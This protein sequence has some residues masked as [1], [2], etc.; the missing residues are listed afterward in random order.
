MEK[1]VFLFRTKPRLIAEMICMNEESYHDLLDIKIKKWNLE[2]IVYL[3]D[4]PFCNNSCS[5]IDSNLLHI[6]L[7]RALKIV[8][9]REE[10][11]KSD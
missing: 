11:Y 10:N 5:H 1:L 3:A 2:E 9:D 7:L 8:T 4:Q 6:N